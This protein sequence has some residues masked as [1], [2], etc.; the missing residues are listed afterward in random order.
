MANNLENFLDGP[1]PGQSLTAELG[2]RP[3]QNPPQYATV[4]QA[5]E[6]YIPRLVEPE[7]VGD[8]INTMETGVPLTT[9]AN[10]MQLGGVMQ[11]YH[12]VDVGVLVLP[13][14][15]E[16]MAYIGDD[17]GISYTTGME[18]PPEPDRPKDTAIA[19]AVKRAK[20]KIDNMEEPQ[21]KEEEVVMP[22][23]KPE[24]TG[25]MARRQ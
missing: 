3:W 13:V 24:Q 6:F 7:F 15:I 16:M 4:E 8:L 9:I 10:A 20:E 5:L 12:T 18:K 22:Q 1:I 23:D 14:L 17:A 11:G 19:V 2:N 21:E 25:L